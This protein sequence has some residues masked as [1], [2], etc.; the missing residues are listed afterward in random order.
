M[1]IDLKVEDEGLYKKIVELLSEYYPNKTF[2]RVKEK[3]KRPYYGISISDEGSLTFDFYDEG[4]KLAKSVDYLRGEWQEGEIKS[5]FYQAL[6]TY[7]YP[8]PWGNLVAVRPSSPLKKQL[9]LEKSERIRY[10]E[11][12]FDVSS[13]RAKLASE[14]YEIEESVLQ[15]SKDSY[16]IYI[17]IPF[18]PSKC[19]YCSFPSLV[20][21]QPE[22]FYDQYIQALI[23]ELKLSRFLYKDKRVG[24]VYIGGGTPASLRAKDFNA[25]FLALEKNY[26]IDNK[27]EITVELGRPELITKEKLDILADFSVNQISIN[28]QSLN[29]NIL[30]EINRGHSKADFFNTYAMVKSFYNFLV[31][32]DLILGLPNEDLLSYQSSLDEV[33][34]LKPDFLTLH[35][36]CVKKGAKLNLDSTQGNYQK[37]K[38]M[39]AYSYQSLFSNHYKPYYLYRQKRMVA[40][41]E[42]VGFSLGGAVN[43]YNL[44]MLS[45]AYPIL[46]FGMGAT[47]K[48]FYGK[49]LKTVLNYRNMKSYLSHYKNTLA[50]KKTY[51]YQEVGD[52]K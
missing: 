33:L 22:A 42:N 18:C 1:M 12:R 48:F 5:L 43:R 27:T 29:D 10:L 9:G 13:F 31:N 21:K 2:C 24:E 16:G 28:A 41:F 14:I 26:R 7:L 45:G 30:R 35:T 49:T 52:D 40:P 47:S 23:D 17:N 20:K 11:E 39:W 25:I 15:R 37:V 36:L 34:K 46:G 44:L 8:L 38:G 51:L 4:I 19:T 6:A 50:E 3:G 32:V